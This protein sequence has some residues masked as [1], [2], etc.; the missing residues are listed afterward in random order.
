M[1]L[2]EIFMKTPIYAWVILVL[3]IKR[4]LSAARGGALSFRN[5]MIFP[6][7]F[8]IWGLE[9]IVTSFVFPWEAISFYV[10][11]AALGAAA[12][13]SIYTKYRT[14][15]EKEGKFYRSGTYMPLAVMM[16]NFLT[17]YVFNVA[18]SINPALYSSIGFNM[19]YA[20]V[21]G[22]SVGL[23]IGGLVQAYKAVHTQY[24]KG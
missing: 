23:T 21:C 9:K 7:V 8:I 6:A 15:Y 20:A 13:Q 22:F 14:I 2:T 1:F 5:M 24:I 3:L 4:G 16:I 11:M 18:M 12:G 17:K 10:L 19:L